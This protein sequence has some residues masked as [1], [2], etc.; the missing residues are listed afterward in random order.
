MRGNYKDI[1]RIALPV[2]AG[3]IAQ[4]SISVADTAMMGRVGTTEVAAI[5]YVSVYYLTLF[6]IG[7]AYTKGTQILVARRVGEDNLRACGSIFDNS[8]LSVMAL[9]FVLF[10]ILRWGSAFF[11]DWMIQD[12]GVRDAGVE[13]LEVRSWGIL[14]SFAGSVFL[15]FF[16]G[17]GTVRVLLVS[18]LVMSTLNIFLNWLFIFG[19]WGVPAMGI[20]GAGLASNIAEFVALSIF[21]VHSM[22]NGIW[23][24]Y[25]MFRWKNISGTVIKLVT[26]ISLPIVLQTLIGLLSWL[27][28][29]YYVEKMGELETAV[30]GIAK[31]IYMFFGV[32]AWGFS[33]AANTVISNLM[34]QERQ[35]RVTYALKN[36]IILSVAVAAAFS[37]PLAIFGKE[38]VAAVYNPEPEVLINTVP[39]IYICIGALLVYSASTVL[40]HGVISTGSVK[41]SLIIEILVVIVYVGYVVAVFSIEDVSLPFVWTCEI[42]YWFLMGFFTLLYLR[43]GH[44]KK[45]KI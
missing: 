41:A 1:I 31:N 9:G 20:T 36:I 23:K 2:I 39:V 42:F 40:Y 30:S 24:K 44:W 18:I 12:I 5:G 3:S 27:F 38:L 14:F 6:M 43:T 32:F 4:T 45:I 19:N 8:M 13:Y 29:F 22:I 37:L 17:L 26:D 21:A 15:A 10:A 28:F 16:M 25:F 33:T 35:Y 11:M 7:F 34:G